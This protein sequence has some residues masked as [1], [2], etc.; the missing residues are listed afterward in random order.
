MQKIDAE[1]EALIVRLYRRLNSSVKVASRLQIGSSTVLRVLGR[2]GI[3]P[4]TRGSEEGRA[5]VTRF[6]GKEAGNVVAAYLG[7]ATMVSMQKKY[8]C[9]AQAIRNAVIRDGGK[10]RPVG[11]LSRAR[12][13]SSSEKRKI[14][15]LYAKG[16]TQTNIAIRFSTTQGKISKLLIASGATIREQHARGE[17]HGSWNGGRCKLDGGYVGVLLDPNDQMFC[18]AR[19]NHYVPEHRIVMARS[20]NRPLTKNESVHHING[21]KMD[22]RLENLQLRHG[23]H[24]NGTV[25]RCSDC[26]SYNIIRVP[27]ANAANGA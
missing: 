6:K 22:N 18:M 2:H 17:R 19:S 20:L 11:G 12:R 1:F 10:V 25:A 8:Q 3:K 14:S 9:S 23:H 27:L 4:P 5:Q 15:D 21:D 7:G 16:W 13:W 26:G 24:G